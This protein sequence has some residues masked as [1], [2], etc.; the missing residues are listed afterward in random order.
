MKT[1][2]IAS[3]KIEALIDFLKFL[4]PEIVLYL[5]ESTI[6]PCFKY[7]SHAWAGASSCYLDMLDQL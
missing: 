4:S 1:G 7:C 6:R 3:K 5:Y 2:L